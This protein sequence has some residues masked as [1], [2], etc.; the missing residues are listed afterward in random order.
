MADEIDLAGDARGSIL[1]RRLLLFFCPLAGSFAQ[2]GPV[3]QLQADLFQGRSA[4]LLSRKAT[5]K[6]APNASSMSVIAP[7]SHGS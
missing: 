4:K 3:V 2:A 1:L 5:I 7:E 6:A